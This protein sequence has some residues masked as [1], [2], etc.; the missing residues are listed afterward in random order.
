MLDHLIAATYL[1]RERQRHLQAANLA[2]EQMRFGLRLAKD[3]KRTWTLPARNTPP[4]VWTK[5]AAWWAAGSRLHTPIPRKHQH[6]FEHIASFE[7]LHHA[8]LN[9]VKGKRKSRVP[10]PSWPG[11]SPSCCAWSASCKT[12]ATAPARTSTLW[13]TT[14][15]AAPSAPHR[16]VT[17]WSTTAEPAQFMGFVTAPVGRRRLP[18]A[19]V[20]RFVCRLRRLR[21]AWQQG[22]VNAAHVQQRKQAWVAHAS[23]AQTAQLRHT[24]FAGGWFDP[25]WANG[26]PVKA[27]VP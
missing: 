7:A 18:D 19:N 6:L 24:L 5:W 14:P 11:W 20:T 23:H 13:Y 16:S 27:H 22:D 2:L 25:F 12:A 17:G 4:A 26:Q 9:A 8:A 15:N 10:P 3:L 1:P 21:A